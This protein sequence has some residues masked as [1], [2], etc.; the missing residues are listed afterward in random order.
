MTNKIDEV[1]LSALKATREV[2]EQLVNSES[3]VM[4]KEVEENLQ[5]LIHICE[6]LEQFPSC[7]SPPVEAIAM[8]VSIAV[9]FPK[10]AAQLSNA[11]IESGEFIS[12]KAIPFGG[13]RMDS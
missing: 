10:E 8:I 6:V 1:R 7:Q 2:M 4:H 5:A 3:S 9:V 11:V 12:E 13:I